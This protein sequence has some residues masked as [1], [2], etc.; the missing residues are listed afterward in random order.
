MKLPK[1]EELLEAGVHYGHQARRWNPKMNPYIFSE[2]AG[3]HIIDLEKTEKQLKE[4]AEFIKTI[5]GRGGVVLFLA[6]KKQSAAIVQ[7][8][9]SRVGALF[10]TV[11]WLGGMLTNFDSIRRT[12]EKLSTL[13]EKIKN[14]N[15]SYTKREQLL[16]QRELDRLKKVIGGVATMNK[17]PDALFIIDSRKEENAVKEA[18]A[19]GIPVVALVDTNADPTKVDHPIVANDDS[20]KSISLLVK[21]IADAYEEG[22]QLWTKTQA[23]EEAKSQ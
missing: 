16:F 22:K 8:E 23:K 12:I 14:E 11:R 6:T 7:S 13:E 15:G 19:M 10:M 20:V 17:L 18:R 3:I 9:A 2:A 4:A 21:T 5:A 1:I